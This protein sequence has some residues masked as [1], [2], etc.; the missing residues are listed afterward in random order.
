VKK[1]T[2]TEDY[3][4]KLAPTLQKGQCHEKCKKMKKH[5]MRKEDKLL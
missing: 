3:S 4:S 5:M 1:Q 2:Y